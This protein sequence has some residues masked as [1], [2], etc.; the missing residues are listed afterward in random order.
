MN[1]LK[2]A[3]NGFLIGGALLTM[4]VGADDCCPSLGA[5]LLYWKVSSCDW[6]YGTLQQATVEPGVIIDQLAINQDYDFGF[7]LFGSLDNACSYLSLDW[8]YL[9]ASDAVEVAPGPDQRLIVNANLSRVDVG[10]KTSYNRVDLR[11]GHHLYRSCGVTLSSYV[12]CNFVDVDEKRRL[13]GIDTENNIHRYTS[14]AEFYG[15]GVEVGFSGSYE[16]CYGVN[17]SARAG[18]LAILGRRKHH[19]LD[20]RPE[21]DLYYLFPSNIQCIPGADLRLGLNTTF[22]CGCSQIFVE[23]GYEIDTFFQM[24]PTRNILSPQVGVARGVGCKTV[25]F[26]GPY[27]SFWLHF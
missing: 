10:L 5:E 12:G 1:K 13:E 11:M 26:A 15:L 23:V 17:L 9:R 4:N 3:L 7:R 16:L 19:A 22:S 8:T 18:G 21:A 25:S 6:D 24:L 27:A 2:T 20:E 14:K